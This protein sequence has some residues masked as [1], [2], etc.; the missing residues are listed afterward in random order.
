MFDSI[1]WVMAPNIDSVRM[2]DWETMNR[3]WEVELEAQ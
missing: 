3:D 1:A 2:K